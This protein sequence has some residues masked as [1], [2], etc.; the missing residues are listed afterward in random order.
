MYMS[1]YFIPAFISAY[2]FLS[3]D[4]LCFSLSLLFHL[5]PWLFII[6]FLS[7]YSFSLFKL[8]C[9]TYCIFYLCF[10]TYLNSLIP[11][12]F[13]FSLCYLSISPVIYSAS[14]ASSH[15]LIHFS[16][17]NYISRSSLESPFKFLF[18][19]LYLFMLKYF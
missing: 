9:Y 13:N 10:Y 5:S 12:T 19:H 14:T 16:I 15:A 6:L 4:S 17:S 18:H 1:T 2:I 7:V 8:Y 3:N 11:Y